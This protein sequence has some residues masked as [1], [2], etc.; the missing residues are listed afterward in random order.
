MLSAEFYFELKME[1][2]KFKIVG[3]AVGDYN[4]ITKDKFYHLK[5]FVN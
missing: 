5:F 4:L 1:N 2:L 3:P